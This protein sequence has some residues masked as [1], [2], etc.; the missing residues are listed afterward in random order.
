M[1]E[2]GEMLS[3]RFRKRT[4]LEYLSHTSGGSFVGDC[5]LEP[6]AQEDLR[7]ADRIRGERASIWR[8]DLYTVRTQTCN[9]KFRSFSIV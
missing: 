9:I 1:G 7:A 6:I 8:H 4:Y 2:S 5:E 3:G